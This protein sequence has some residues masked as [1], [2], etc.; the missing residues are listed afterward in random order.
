MYTI[1]VGIQGLMSGSYNNSAI[2]VQPKPGSI[3]MSRLSVP[4]LESATGDTAKVYDQIKKAVGNVPNTFA[5]I[6]AHGPA[7]LRAVLAADGVLAAGTLPKRDQETI[8]LLVSSVP[9]CDYWVAPH[10]LLRKV[11]RLK[12]EVRRHNSEAQA[13]H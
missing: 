2:V 5:A 7:A 11:P 3:T 9:G 6:G 4:N 13:T 8:K 1:F 10:T 12:P